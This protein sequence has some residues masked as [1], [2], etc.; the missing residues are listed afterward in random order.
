[1]S[2][3]VPNFRLYPIRM[4]SLNLNLIQF[5]LSVDLQNRHLR[6]LDILT[7]YDQ[8][9]ETSRHLTSHRHNSGHLD[10]LTSHD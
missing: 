8:D 9:T 10:I 6:H 1:M 3:Q 2:T 4:A 7:S 5:N